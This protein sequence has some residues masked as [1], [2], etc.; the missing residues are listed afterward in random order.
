MEAPEALC[1]V[2]DGNI[3][4]AKTEVTKRVTFDIWP[5]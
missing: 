5:V 2:Q 3:Q 4:F 1:A